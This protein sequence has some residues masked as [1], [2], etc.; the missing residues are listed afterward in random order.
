MEELAREFAEQ[1]HFLFI[2]TRE[3]HPGEVF[4]PHASYEQKVRHA[5]AFRERGLAR[6]ILM[7]TLDG[8][9]HRLYGGVSNMT[10][11]VDHTGHVAYKASWTDAVDIRGALDETL[12]IRERRREGGN[13]SPFYREIVGVRRYHP[14]PSEGPRFLGGKKAEED[15]RRYWERVG[16]ESPSS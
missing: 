15:V 12:K 11:I 13:V 10:W 6:P 2:Y 14:P 7:D 1:T 16:R 8:Q 4:P 5:A 9:V 3:A